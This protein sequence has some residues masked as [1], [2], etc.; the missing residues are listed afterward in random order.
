MKALL[1][2]P[3]AGLLAAA[4]PAAP[5]KDYIVSASW[6]KEHLGEPDLVVLGLDMPS[7]GSI[8]ESY[9][10]GHIPGARMLDFH[11]IMQGDGNNGTN[12]MELVSDDS[13]RSYLEGLGIGDKSRVVLYGPTRMVTAIARVFF[14]F[15]HLGLGDRT[16]ILD[17]GMGAWTKA[18]GA[19]ETTTITN[20]ARGTLH[21]TAAHNVV[22]GDWLK[23][24][25]DD[26]KYFVIDA[27][28][29]EFY[30]GEKLGHQAARQGH[31]PGAANLYYTAMLD[32]VAGTWRST[33]EAKE[34]FAKAGLPTDRTLIVYCHI[35]QTANVV[36]T[37]ARRLGIPVKLYDGSFQEW[38]HR[39]ELGIATK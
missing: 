14:T 20:V 23:A 6:L 17:G 12:T 10:V 31:I 4:T 27:R 21:L 2:L 30:S 15:D 7:M 1:L 34:L 3:L 24:H 33:A 29:P 37:Q 35:G 38:S 28:A 26:K 36:Y 5:P 18:G 13:L 9:R 19:V 8:P 11:A 32:T 22:S 16:F 25:L 39:A